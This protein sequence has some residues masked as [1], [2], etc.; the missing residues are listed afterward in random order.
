MTE[1]VF[2]PLKSASGAILGHARIADGVC[3]LHLRR[4]VHGQAVVLSEHGTWSCGVEEEIG[5]RGKLCA[6]AVLEDGRLL[7]CGIP[8]GQRIDFTALQRQLASKSRESAPSAAPQPDIPKNPA[9]TV[10]SAAAACSDPQ[11]APRPAEALPRQ[12]LRTAKRPRRKPSVA[13]AATG[14][15]GCPSAAEDEPPMAAR[16]FAPLAEQQQEELPN[17]MAQP[18]PQMPSED[19]LPASHLDRASAAELHDPAWETLAEAAEPIRLFD[20]GNAMPSMT[21]SAADAESFAALMRRAELVFHS[22][23]S[24]QPPL[25]QSSAW[26]TP[27][28]ESSRTVRTAAGSA[29][30]RSWGQEV[31]ILL[32]DRPAQSKTAIDNPFPHIFPNAVFYSIE[33]SGVQQHLEGDWQSGSEHLRIYAVPGSY[34][35][36]PPAHLKGYTR[37]IR[38]QQG[39]YWVRVTGER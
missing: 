34:S 35:P 30:Q 2:L 23:E 36:Q 1:V 18:S 28:S 15:L 7:C 32:G 26:N 10:Q 6:I 39:S 20:G 5:V 19:P 8:Q 11:P 22:I 3:R 12:I 16:T 4:P 21:D 33:G 9:P 38:T 13:A 37:F 31:A 17:F 24:P 14:T 27:L 25:I 29:A